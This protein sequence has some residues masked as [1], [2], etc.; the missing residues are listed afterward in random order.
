MTWSVS[1][2]S[3]G[4]THIR[5]QVS[6]PTPL[7][8]THAYIHPALQEDFEPQHE[9]KLLEELK[10]ILEYIPHSELAIQ[11]DTA[12]EFAI[13]EGIMPT[14][15]RNMESEINEM[16][17]RLAARVPEPVELGFHLCYGDAGHKH[18]CEPKDMSKLVAVSQSKREDR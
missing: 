5:F 1:T 2:T 14:Y 17:L 8:I 3:P 11:W 7:A 6:L 15:I 9:K 16:L 10:D 4:S 18:F 13:L 12:V